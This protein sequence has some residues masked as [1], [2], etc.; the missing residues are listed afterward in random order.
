MMTTAIASIALV[1]L[2]FSTETMAS[3]SISPGMACT[4]SITRCSSMSSW[5]SQKPHARPMTMPDHRPDADREEPDPQRDA[6]AVDDAAED[7]SADIVGPEGV[8][9]AGA[10]QADRGIRVERIVRGNDVRE[11]R[12]QHHDRDQERGCRAEGLALDRRPQG[13][14]ATDL[15][16]LFDL[17]DG[18]RDDVH[19]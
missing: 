19:R 16:G 5:P 13:T 7:V 17:A 12:G 15:D 1:V 9:G 8:R 2:G 6:G 3:A 14:D 10:R 4:A 18:S 11:D